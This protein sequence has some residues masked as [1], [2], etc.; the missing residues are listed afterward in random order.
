M[1][2]YR[3]FVANRHGNDEDFEEAAMGVASEAGEIAQLVRKKRFESHYI[4]DIDMA[5]E[6]GDVLHYVEMIG[7]TLDVSDDELKM[8]NC[9]KLAERD[10]GREEDMMTW[11]RLEER[12]RNHP[13][14]FVRDIYVELMDMFERGEPWPWETGVSGTRENATYIINY[15]ED[16]DFYRVNWCNLCGGDTTKGSRACYWFKSK[17]GID[18]SQGVFERTDMD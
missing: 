13:P 14:T 12:I 17:E 18:D 10:H 4:N 7:I 15:C 1:K 3:E 9:I 8:L 6:A 11:L 5:M 2:E 16:C